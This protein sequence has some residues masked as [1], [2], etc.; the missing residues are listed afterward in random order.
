MAK[1]LASIETLRSDFVSNISH[2]FK[3]PVASIRGFAKRLMKENL[4]QEQ[5]N[6]YL[7]IIVSE[8]ERLAQLS[9]NVLLLSNLEFGSPRI[10]KNE[11]SLDEQIR[12][13]VLLLEP[14]FQKKQ[15]ELTLHF[16]ETKIFASE[17]L[18]YHCWLNLI[19]NAIKFCEMRGEI[20]ISLSQNKNNA[21]VKISD[22]G[23]G[24][25]ETVKKRIFEKFYQADT[26]RAAEGN[27]LGLSLVKKILD[28]QNGCITVQSETGKGTEFIVSL[29][30]TTA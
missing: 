11:F 9:G 5:R 18:L 7:K 1:E 25:D 23:V 10:E 27:G 8:S 20:N 14:Q 2:E 30:N 3:T 12:K 16:E 4:P 24:M 17:E 28:I 21:V 26:S 22:N 19:G 15:I 6:D 29:G 13:I